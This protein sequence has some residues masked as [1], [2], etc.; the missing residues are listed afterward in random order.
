MVST[1][2][3]FAFLAAAAVTDFRSRKIYNWTTYPGILTALGLGGMVSLFGQQENV[4]QL[5]GTIAL[6]DSLL[7][8]A[9]CGGCML[10]CY[11]FFRIG[12]GDVKLI[13]MV[14]A[15]LGPQYGLKAMLW[16][17]VIGGAFALIFLVWRMGSWNLIKRFV[18]FAAALL[19]LRSASHLGG[20][21]DAE[22]QASLFLAPSALV[23]VVLVQIESIRGL[24]LV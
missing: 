14:G 20:S 22:V 3:M 11:V 8:L 4:Q 24:L 17:F 19:R 15:F 5:L 7:G 12:G 13:A 1:F 18:Q 6:K 10:V 21:L 9:L 16:T 2:L 23:A